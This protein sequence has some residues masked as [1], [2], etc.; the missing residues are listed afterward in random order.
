MGYTSPIMP[1]DARK[2]G[3]LAAQTLTVAA[4]LALLVSLFLTW[5]RLTLHQLALVA[6]SANGSLGGL[7]LHHNAWGTSAAIATALTLVAL[8]IAAVGALNRIRLILP[9][10]VLS[11][12]AL[13]LVI[14]LLLNPPSAVPRGVTTG[15]PAVLGSRAPAGGQGAGGPGET[16]ALIALV[17]GGAGMWA[18]LHSAH[19]D[20]RRRRGQQPA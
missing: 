17:L 14:A 2:T 19:A 16:V 20:R 3:R 7:S 18:L 12:A 1:V 6:L 13:G 11:L 4:A 5:S 10:A 15:A 9:V 8:A